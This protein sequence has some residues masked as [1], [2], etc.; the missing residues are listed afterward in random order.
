MSRRRAAAAITARDWPVELLVL[1][2]AQDQDK[3]TWSHQGTAQSSRDRIRHVQKETV[4]PPDN[5]SHSQPS[6]PPLGEAAGKRPGRH[7]KGKGS[8]TRSSQVQKVLGS[9]SPRAPTR[10][11]EQN[12]GARSGTRHSLKGQQIESAAKASHLKSREMTEQR[13]LGHRLEKG[14]AREEG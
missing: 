12:R 7:C 1:F 6:W 14:K 11:D 8:C 10:A 2:S 9:E 13:G 5:T 4:P 3:R